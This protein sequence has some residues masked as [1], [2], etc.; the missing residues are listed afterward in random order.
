MKGESKKSSRK[1]SK[2]MSGSTCSPG[3]AGGTTPS[4]SRGG[5][6][7]CGQ[8]PAPASHTR[9]PAG[10]GAQKT[11]DIFGRR[12][13]GSSLSHV[14][15]LSLENR[16][17][18]RMDVNGSPEYALTWKTW[19]IAWG[20]PICALRARGHRILGRDCGGWPSPNTPSG[21]RSVSVEKMDATGR[22][23]DGK[24]HTA[25][26]EH[27]VKFAGWTTP[28]AHDVTPRGKGQKA[29]HGTTHGCG[30]LNRDAQAA[31]WASPT[32]HEKSRSVEWQKGRELNPREALGAIPY[33]SP[34][35]T[36][37]RDG[38]QPDGWRS[39]TAGSPNSLRGRGQD[40]E[41][42]KAQGHTVNLQDQV[43]LAGNT[44]LRLNPRFSLWL[45]GYPDGWASCGERGIASS[46]K[47]RRSS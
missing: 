1:T 14:L 3:S 45:Q 12:D 19:D 4:A 18:A 44:S 39:P 9:A 36:E 2:D 8:C 10:V 16:L 23:A 29:K 15:Q 28:Q 34:A 24:K 6:G 26:L 31:G 40:P 11:L 22:T 21:G 17:R 38:Y 41:K 37:R 33:S 46:R 30:D 47:S 25:S 35:R 7:P 5:K 20:P 27:A 13:G 43:R 42:R 32:A